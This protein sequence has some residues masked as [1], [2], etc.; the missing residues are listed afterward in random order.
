[1]WQIVAGVYPHNDW[2]IAIWPVFPDDLSRKPASILG[3]DY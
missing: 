2:H 1:M 3:F